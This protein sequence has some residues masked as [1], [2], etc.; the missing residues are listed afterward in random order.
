M[1]Y[2]LWPD[3]VSEVG[4]DA[5]ILI[6]QKQASLL[7]KLTNH[8][9]EAKVCRA[10]G[11]IPS[12]KH[13]FRY[14]FGLIAPILG[15]YSYHLLSTTHYLDLY[16]VVFHLDDEMQKEL[17]NELGTWPSKLT[18]KSE[19]DFLSILKAIFH[20]Q[21]T[22]GVIG[23]MIAQSKDYEPDKEYPF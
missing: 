14:H 3:E 21:K 7:G 18:A 1:T 10:D 19:N 15:N 4:T 12:E 17:A 16:P 23:R 2:F 5:P 20:A 11:Y 8:A 13:G 9:V 22:R 6:L